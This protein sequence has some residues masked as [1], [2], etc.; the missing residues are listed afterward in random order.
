M[1]KNILLLIVVFSLT[2]IQEVD[3]KNI[4]KWEKIES[5]VKIVRK[6][7]K[8]PPEAINLLQNMGVA[9]SADKIA[10]YKHKNK[11]LIIGHNK[12]L[13]GELIIFLSYN[14][15]QTWHLYFDEV[16]E[17]NFDKM[18]KH[19]DINNA[20]FSGDKLIIPGKKHIFYSNFKDTCEFIPLE[21]YPADNPLYPDNSKISYSTDGEY[22]YRECY[23]DD[24][25]TIIRTKDLGKTWDT[26][27]APFS[28][29]S[30][31]ISL[32]P[33]TNKFSALINR[34]NVANASEK[35]DY[36]VF[37][38]TDMKGTHN[39]SKLPIG[40]GTDFTYDFV[41]S[42]NFINEN[43][44][45]IVGYGKRNEVS[46]TPPKDWTAQLSISKTTDG[47][48][49][50]ELLND[51]LLTLINENGYKI[52]RI[53][54]SDDGLNGIVCAVIFSD[55]ENETPVKSD[56]CPLYITTDGGKT[57]HTDSLPGFRNMMYYEEGKEWFHADAVLNAFCTSPTTIILHTFQNEAL[58]FG[59]KISSI[60]EA[61]LK[62]TLLY[63]NP[64]SSTCTISGNLS[65]LVQDFSITI[66][67]INGKEL[68]EVCKHQNLEG[69]FSFSFDTKSLP[70]GSYN[71][72]LN[73]DGKKQIEKL[74]IER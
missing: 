22:I 13:V 3:A 60:A 31:Y 20:F 17:E 1:K 37:Y 24:I 6:S 11:A 14:L 4:Y 53:S 33:S 28:D 29:S 23:I 2:S 27:P 63:P 47:G 15:G 52:P 44:G 68:F 10:F 49:T 26:L 32:F 21:S 62:S 61:P 30:Y 9:F 73:A 19:V 38:T 71:V 18:L 70:S 66:S 58:Y 41:G 40:K 72:I 57:W 16:L 74:I 7:T 46:N 45:W 36:P 35:Y 54:F 39:F 64:A 42:V 55:F 50:W 65:A 59:R 8:Y 48:S 67:D 34:R 43:Q 5:F 12:N 51:T 69:E 25:A 56:I